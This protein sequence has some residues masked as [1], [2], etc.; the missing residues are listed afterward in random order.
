MFDKG[1]IKVKR[2]I[3]HPKFDEK[4]L[5]NNIVLLELEK[6][7]SFGSGVLPGCLDMQNSSRSFGDLVATGYGFTSKFVLYHGFPVGSPKSSRFL[8]E[9]ESKDISSTEPRCQTFKDTICIDSKSA[10]TDESICFGD[11]GKFS[12]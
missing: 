10:G 12:F 4:T 5:E 8:K 6:P 9:L 7:L 1:R 2:S 3:V 11:E